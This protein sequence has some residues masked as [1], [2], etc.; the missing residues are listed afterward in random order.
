MSAKEFDWF[1]KNGFPLYDFEVR[2]TVDGF[3]GVG[4]GTDAV[5]TV[6]LEKAIAEAVERAVCASVR[7]SSM[8][9]AAHI[10]RDLS[11]NNAYREALERFAFER[12]LR[13]KRSFSPVQPRSVQT[14]IPEMRFYRMDLP[15]PFFALICFLDVGDGR[16]L[17][18]S[19]ETDIEAAFEKATFEVLRNFAVYQDNPSTFQKEVETNSDLWCCRQDFLS[20]V[21]A[22]FSESSFEKDS[23]PLPSHLFET[24][25]ISHLLTLHDCPVVVSRCVLAEDVL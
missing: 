16:F 13:E 2:L 9:V 15:A 8:G 6:A 24:I 5:E 7:I 3:L 14:L 11:E 20:Q 12:H 21:E 25:Q 1:W 19:C 4:R 18:L 17:G 10:R 22:L 23:F